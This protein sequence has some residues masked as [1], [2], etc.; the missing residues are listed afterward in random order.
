MIPL[1][2]TKLRKNDEIRNPKKAYMLPDSSFDL[3]V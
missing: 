3:R 2:G 1:G